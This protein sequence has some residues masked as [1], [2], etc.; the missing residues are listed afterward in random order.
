MQLNSTNYYKLFDRN[1][2]IK[3]KLNLV[4]GR[5]V[6]YNEQWKYLQVTS[7]SILI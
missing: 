1:V 2:E 5:K 6:K 3:R 7:F 4:W